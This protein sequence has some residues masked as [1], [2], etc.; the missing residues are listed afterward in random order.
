M[1]RAIDRC[2]AVA[3]VHRDAGALEETWLDE[4]EIVGAHL[5]EVGRQRNAVVGEPRLLAEGRDPVGAHSSF[6]D[7]AGE[8]PMAHHTV[9]D[10]HQVLLALVHVRRFMDHVS[11]LIFDAPWRSI[12]STG[13]C[14]PHQFRDLEG[15]VDDLV[16]AEKMSRHIG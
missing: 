3:D 9:T 2:C 11:D 10:D 1:R 4:R 16:M 6:R 15:L 7:E 5:V 12:P 8:Q 13:V 14:D